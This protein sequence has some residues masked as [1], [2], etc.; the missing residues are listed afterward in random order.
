MVK[1]DDLNTYVH[2]VCRIRT[3]LFTI[4]NAQC[5]EWCWRES[6]QN[7]WMRLHICQN[8]IFRFFLMKNKNYISRTHENPRM[9]IQNINNTLENIGSL[10]HNTVEHIMCSNRFRVHSIEAMWSSGAGCKSPPYGCLVWNCV[11]K[12]RWGFKKVAD[13]K[14]YRSLDILNLH[15]IHRDEDIARSRC[16]AHH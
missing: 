14:L 8:I 16:E 1:Q 13:K 11:G 12:S 4:F 3:E 5:L 9:I 2:Y 10:K 6:Y 7:K 15:I